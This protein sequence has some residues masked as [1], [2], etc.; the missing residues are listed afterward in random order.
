MVEA[1]LNTTFQRAC[2]LAASSP[3]TGDWLFALPIASCGLQLDDEAVRIAV[4]IRLGLVICV[5]HQC[6]CGE[7][8]DAFGIHSFVCKR[9][10][11]GSHG[12]RPS[13]R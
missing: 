3:H 6:H 13:M 12:T 8:V 4:G 2:F 10:Q 5:P 9:F 7:Q 11:A 1:N